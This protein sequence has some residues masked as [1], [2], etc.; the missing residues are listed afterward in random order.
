MPSWATSAG[1]VVVSNS[2]FSRRAI[3]RDE[4][5]ALFVSDGF[6]E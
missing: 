2:E 4:V 3:T 6:F 1:D 5:M